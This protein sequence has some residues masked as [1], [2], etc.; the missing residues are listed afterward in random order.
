[1]AIPLPLLFGAAALLVLGRKKKRRKTSDRL[2]EP[3]EAPGAG[4]PEPDS[5]APGEGYITH[6]PSTALPPIVGWNASIESRARAMMTAGWEAGNKVLS[7]GKLF[8][9]MRNTAMAMWPHVAWPITIN[10]EMRMVEVAP[11]NRIPRW[12]YNLGNEGPKAL[13]IWLRLRDLAWNITGYKPPV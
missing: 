10:D 12:V 6:R 9:L 13:N 1:M 7:G 2:G 4:W 8:I 5:R 3:D 11:G